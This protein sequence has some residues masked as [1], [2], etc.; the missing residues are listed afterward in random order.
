LKQNLFDHIFVFE[1]YPR[2]EEISRLSNLKSF[3]QSNYSLNFIIMPGENLSLIFTYNGNLYDSN[4]IKK[5]AGHIQEVIDL[6]LENRNIQV[7]DIK[8]TQYFSHTTSKI[9]KD[10]DSDF[11]F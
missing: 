6:V 9:H 5:M 2:I 3:E 11:E 7:K 4:F 10:G 8:I 1:N